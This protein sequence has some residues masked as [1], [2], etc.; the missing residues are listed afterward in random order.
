MISMAPR[1][2]HSGQDLGSSILPL[3]AAKDEISGQVS[4]SS[5]NI[6]QHELAT[7]E[8]CCLC[9]AYFNHCKAAAG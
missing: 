4:V 3:L 7:T 8:A 9:A 6:A 2:W 1:V 5:D